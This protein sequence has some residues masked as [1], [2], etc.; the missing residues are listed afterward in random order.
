M[1]PL[2]EQVI[3][4]GTEGINIL[5]L[6]QDGKGYGKTEFLPF[7]IKN[8][9]LI[10]G[11]RIVH[12]FMTAD[13]NL[14]S[15]GRIPRTLIPNQDVRTSSGDG[16]EFTYNN[17]RV[18]NLGYSE[19]L[20]EVEDG[21]IL[22]D[23]INARFYIVPTTG[24]ITYILTQY[25][26]SEGDFQLGCIVRDKGIYVTFP[27]ADLTTEVEITQRDLGVTSGKNLTSV[28]VGG[29]GVFEAGMEIVATAIHGEEFNKRVRCNQ[30]GAAYINIHG[31]AFRIALEATAAQELINQ[32]QLDYLTIVVQTNDRRF[33]EGFRVDQT[34][35]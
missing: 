27:A 15:V 14:W 29:S 32:L 5:S 11:N 9:N 1:A 20:S 22:L 21:N 17:I 19:H 7:G 4:Y 24:E 30:D 26:L 25:G 6:T 33:T 31:N 3:V 34:A 28:K 2:G 35:T 18:R 23:P 10:A 8:R 13:N 16:K 12:V